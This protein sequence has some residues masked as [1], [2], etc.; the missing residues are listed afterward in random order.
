MTNKT[1][2]KASAP[3]VEYVTL[4]RKKALCHDLLETSLK[5]RA[6]MEQ[7]GE[8]SSPTNVAQ[9]DFQTRCYVG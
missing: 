6:G 1:E 8:C 9:L 7:W 2:R 4:Q 3:R 5:L